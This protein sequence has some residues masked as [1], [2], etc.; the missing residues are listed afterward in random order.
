MSLDKTLSFY[1]ESI[2]RI[3]CLFTQS[4]NYYQGKEKWKNLKKLQQHS[5][6]TANATVIRNALLQAGGDSSKQF[7]IKYLSKNLCE[8]EFTEELQT[9]W[10]GILF[11]ASHI[12]LMMYFCDQA[13]N[14]QY[15]YVMSQC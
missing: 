5:V 3:Q 14:D 9:I 7:L 4:T 8:I 10:M 6:F 15:L 2:R 12:G 1:V 11:S 13:T